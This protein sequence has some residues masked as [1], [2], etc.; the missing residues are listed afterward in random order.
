M[1]GSVLIH[2]PAFR[3]FGFCG[4][5]FQGIDFGVLAPWGVQD[6]KGYTA[7]VIPSYVVA[8]IQAFID[9]HRLQTLHPVMKLDEGKYG[10]T[11]T[12]VDGNAI[13]SW[14]DKKN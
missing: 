11:I 1:D 7:A 6:Q 3:E 10:V 14:M 13:R 4:C 9:H 12:V 2:H 8:D 5:D